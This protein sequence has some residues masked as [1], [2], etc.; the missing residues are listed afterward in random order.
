MAMYQS[1]SGGADSKVLSVATGSSLVATRGNS[2]TPATLKGMLGGQGILL[3][4]SG[5]D[6]TITSNS[7]P[8]TS[9]GSGLS[10]IDPSS[11]PL[12]KYLVSLAVQN[13]L[14]LDRNAGVV[15]LGLGS[16]LKAKTLQS[17]GGLNAVTLTNAGV[18]LILDQMFDAD[19][20][21][22]APFDQQNQLILPKDLKCATL[23]A[24]S[25]K[26]DN[27]FVAGD[28]LA[29]PSATQF[30]ALSDSLAS[31]TSSASTS[32]VALTNRVSSL[33]TDNTANK[34]NISSLTTRA[35][36]VE[37]SSPQRPHLPP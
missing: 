28:S 26:A 17:T 18:N 10:L 15:T 1:T 20:N 25:I 16:T 9:V 8:I 5:T 29:I 21:L 7:V 27:L 34:S 22:L 36:A 19:G 31:L 12:A 4:E 11:T 13:G 14:S 30:K 37:S 33:E 32:S 2:G 6:I 35:T 24:Q 23:T 3:S